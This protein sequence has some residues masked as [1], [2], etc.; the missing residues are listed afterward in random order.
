MTSSDSTIITEQTAEV[1][2]EELA[3]YQRWQVPNID[4]VTVEDIDEEQEPKGLLSVEEIEAIQKQAHHEG[5]QAGLEQGKQEGLKLGQEE[6]Y[7]AGYSAGEADMASHLHRL[8]DILSVLQAP[9]AIVDDELEQSVM[10][11]VKLLAK[12]VIQTELK[13]SPEHIMQVIRSSMALLPINNRQLTVFL[14]P[15]DMALVK[16]DEQFA[17][18]NTDWS[19]QIDT[20]LSRGGCRISTLNTD[21]DASVE[22]QIA[23]AIEQQLVAEVIDE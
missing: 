11:L 3:Q 17:S 23:K 8:N 14:H 7:Q 1:T 6:G 5:Y 22:Q 9:L 18:D 10:A 19:W 20:S 13:L 2:A 16:A 4:N 15:E 21:I 12:R